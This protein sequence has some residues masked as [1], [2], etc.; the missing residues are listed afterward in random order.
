MLRTRGRGVR[1][2]QVVPE[3]YWS[4]FSVLVISKCMRQY[5]TGFYVYAY[6][7]ND[8]TPYYIGKGKGDRAW[9]KRQHETKP[10]KDITKIV[11]LEQN[12]TEIGALAIERRIIRWYGRK[13]L[14][15]GIL[16]N[17]TDGGD[18]NFGLKHTDQ[19]KQILR[20]KALNAYKE[21]TSNGISAKIERYKATVE[22]RKQNPLWKGNYKTVSMSDRVWINNGVDN[23]RHKMDQAIPDGWIKGRLTKE[24]NDPR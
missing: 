21:L 11:V 4:G 24:K 8:G 19:T 13:D 20:E 2:S 14:G 3:L 6:L 12:L 16:R 22:K 1:I 17:K 7:R 15:T 23:K 10:P 5:P 18:G 9:H